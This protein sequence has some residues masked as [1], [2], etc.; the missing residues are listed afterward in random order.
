MENSE[1]KSLIDNAIEALKKSAVEMEKFQ[2]K[3]ALG[4]AEAK[5]SYEE[6]KKKLNLFIH[7]SKFKIKS[8]KQKVDD[9]NTKLDELRVQLNLGKVESIEAFNHQKKRLLLTIHELEVKIKSNERLKKIYAIVLIEIETFKIQLEILEVKLNQN[10]V[11]TELSIK[12]SKENFHQFIEKLHV[13]YGKKKET[14][15]EHFHNEISEAFDHL[16]RAFN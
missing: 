12:K 14:K 1:S 10:M 3:V 15:W 9:V 7:E 4:K 6:I 5:D 16:K 11:K 13:K 8:G 2:V